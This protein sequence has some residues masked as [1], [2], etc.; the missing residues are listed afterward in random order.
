M[1]SPK[2]AE[3]SAAQR[4]E[5]SAAKTF[6]TEKER[7]SRIFGGHVDRSRTDEAWSVF[8]L[9]NP[10]TQTPFFVGFAKEGETA[11]AYGLPE[12]HCEHAKNVMRAIREIGMDTQLVRLDLKEDR[13]SAKMGSLFWCELLGSRG[14]KLVN[15]PSQKMA[16]AALLEHLGQCAMRSLEETTS[17]QS[18]HTTGLGLGAVSLQVVTRDTEHPQ[19]SA[20]RMTDA[21]GGC[22]DTAR[23][24]SDRFARSAAGL[25]KSMKLMESNGG[26]H[27]VSAS[28]PSPM[29]TR[30]DVQS[31]VE[32]CRDEPHRVE[33]STKRPAKHGQKW[34]AYDTY[35]LT[36]KIVAGLNFWSI[37]EELERSARSILVKLNELSLKDRELRSKLIDQGILDEVSGEMRTPKRVEHASKP[38]ASDA[39]SLASVGHSA[40]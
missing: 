10:V 36:S 2:N 16:N 1:H 8:L 38:R 32:S 40:F 13:E 37:Q 12:T 21:S 33:G 14:I 6:D 9:I 31:P 22:Q 24:E 3:M 19:P 5:F 18:A 4:H 39:F 25:A 15:L 23:S 20:A 30:T 17:R 27:P 7:L 34:S 29:S 26:I 28:S 11:D 35:N